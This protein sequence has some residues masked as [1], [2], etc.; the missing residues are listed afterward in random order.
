MLQWLRRRQQAARLA[1]AD[2]EALIR[3]HGAEAWREA[4]QRERD[5]I[6]PDG[7]THAGRMP[8]HWRRVALIVANR[9]GHRVGLDTATRMAK[10]ADFSPDQKSGGPPA[11]VHSPPPDP[12]KEL[13]HS[14]AEVTAR[15]RTCRTSLWRWPRAN[16]ALGEHQ[17]GGRF[18]CPL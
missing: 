1:Q 15:T 12:L 13:K 10:D 16:G 4:R 18:W 6:L 14:L 2:A 11:H 7:T 17:A 9:T 8:A 5:V 3:D